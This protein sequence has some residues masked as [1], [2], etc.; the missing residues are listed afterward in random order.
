MY[1]VIKPN[2]GTASALQ[3]YVVHKVYIKCFKPQPRSRS[4]SS[5]HQAADVENRPTSNEKTSIIWRI[6]SSCTNLPDSCN[7]GRTGHELTPL[8]IF[9]H[10]TLHLNEP[11]LNTSTHR[12]SNVSNKRVQ[13][14]SHATFRSPSLEGSFSTENVTNGGA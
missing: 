3:S 14:R 9:L 13:Q 2:T 6:T 12:C 1:A 8:G 7:C 5:I 4:P 11:L 10:S